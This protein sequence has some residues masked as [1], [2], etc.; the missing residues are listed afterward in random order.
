MIIFCISL[1]V[2]DVKAQT[3]SCRLR[4]SLLT[5]GPGDDLYSIW[6]HTGIRVID[7]VHQADVVF[8]YGTFNDRDP[9]FYIKF[10]RGI[11]LYSV[12]PYAFSDFMTEY[13][14]GGRSVTEQVL[15]LNCAEKIQLTAAL[16]KNTEKENRDY[17][18]HF[19][20]DNCTT[21]ARD[22]LMNHMDTGVQYKNI[23]PQPASST[24]RQL[25]H[26]YMN[27]SSQAWNRFAIDV[28][29]GNHL[30]ET[31]TNKQAMFLPD[32]LMKGVD[33]ATIRQQSLVSETNILLPDARQ[34]NSSFFTPAS[35]FALLLLL[36]LALTFVQNKTAKKTALVLDSLLF[37]LTGLLG[38]LMAVLWLARVDL[39]CRN[40]FNLL[41]ALPTHAIIAFVVNKQKTWIKYYWLLTAVI[42]ALLLLTWKW[43][44]QDMNSS[45][46]LLV[47]LL[48][49]R[50][51]VRW[52]N[53]KK[54]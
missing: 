26:S 30:D 10:T 36:M 35:L 34:K 11:M 54:A 25:I 39:V 45:L 44:P 6:G 19:Y 49:F 48:L 12:A 13:Q 16:W 22:M 1:L 2:Q 17:P 38:V 9:L 40:N 3:D 32:Y 28:L 47:L 23:R 18:Y 21:R 43:L 5:C 20:A 14:E 42:N 7:S 33:S 27:S 51:L 8:N 29:L 50:S 41:W 24:Y 37:L 15:Q 46:L 4:I 31:M 53:I 52:Q